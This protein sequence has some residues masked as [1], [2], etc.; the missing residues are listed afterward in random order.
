MDS[1]LVAAGQDAGR[2]ASYR[3]DLESGNL[4]PLDVIQIG[5]RPSWVLF[6][7]LG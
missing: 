3:I 6:V 2:L 7:E 4:D 1:V 5:E